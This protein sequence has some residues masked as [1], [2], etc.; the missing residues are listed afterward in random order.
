M[1][2]CQPEDKSYAPLFKLESIVSYGSNDSF[3]VT[4]NA[5]ATY[6]LLHDVEMI[7]RT[8]DNVQIFTVPDYVER[9][10]HSV[11]STRGVI[12]PIDTDYTV[13]LRAVTDEFYGQWQEIE[14]TTTDGFVGGLVDLTH[15]GVLIEH[16]GE[17]VQV[18]RG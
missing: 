12:L 3:Y 11:E 10:T 16:L 13:W 4:W 8:A 6:D 2:N 9:V 17:P 15:D 7:Y 14:V 5:N 1:T 18:P